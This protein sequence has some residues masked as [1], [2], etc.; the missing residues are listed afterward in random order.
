MVD[1]QNGKRPDRKER[2]RNEEMR[3][4]QRKLRANLKLRQRINAQPDTENVIG[5]LNEPSGE[6]R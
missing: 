5:C 1:H 3:I 4:R 6:L 2:N